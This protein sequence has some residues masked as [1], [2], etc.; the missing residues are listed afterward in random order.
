MSSRLDVDRYHYLI[1]HE[2]ADVGDSVGVFGPGLVLLLL[3]LTPLLGVQGYT[4]VF[5]EHYGWR[6][7]FIVSAMRAR[8]SGGSRE[9]AACSGGVIS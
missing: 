4:W 6:H 2:S 9:M 3:V 1:R 8:A 5:G 7:A